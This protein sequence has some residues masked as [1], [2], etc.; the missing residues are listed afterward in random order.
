V[1][2]EGLALDLGSES[3]SICESRLDPAPQPCFRPPVGQHWGQAFDLYAVLEH[4][5]GGNSVRIE[6][7]EYATSGFDDDHDDPHT[8]RELLCQGLDDRQLPDTATSP[9]RKEVDDHDAFHVGDLFARG[10]RGEGL[11]FSVRRSDQADR[12]KSCDQ[13]NVSEHVGSY[14]DSIHGPEVS[15]RTCH[16]GVALARLPSQPVQLEPDT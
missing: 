13:G 3:R 15:Q 6:F 12:E 9:L 14:L 5:V 2:V 4:Q 8:P 10:L 1:L 16:L 11:E 7:R